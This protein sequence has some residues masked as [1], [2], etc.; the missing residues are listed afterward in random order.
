MA[1]YTRAQK[2][3]YYSGM[4]YRA[5]HEGKAIPFKSEKNKES[6]RRGYKKAGESVKKYPNL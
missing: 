4:G 1:K 3:A 6:F 5:A 2:K